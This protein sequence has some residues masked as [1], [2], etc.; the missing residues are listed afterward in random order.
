MVT[1][2]LTNLF[3]LLDKIGALGPRSFSRDHSIEPEVQYC[4]VQYPKERVPHSY[5]YGFLIL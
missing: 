2:M 1:V 5:P 4:T 3:T